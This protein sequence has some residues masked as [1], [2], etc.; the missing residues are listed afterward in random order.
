MLRS[1]GGRKSFSLFGVQTVGDLRT[2]LHQIGF[3]LE[4]FTVG[5]LKVVNRV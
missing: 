3:D 4:N 5:L 1:G 2:Q